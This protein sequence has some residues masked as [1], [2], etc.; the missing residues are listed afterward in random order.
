MKNVKFGLL[1]TS[2]VLATSLFLASCNKSEPAAQQP[3]AEQSQAPAASA[4]QSDIANFPLDPAKYTL[5]AEQVFS[6]NLSG[7]PSSMDPAAVSDEL[8]LNAQIPIFETLTRQENKTGEFVPAAAESYSVSEDGKTWTFKLRPN[9]VWSDGV[10]VKAED[11]VYAFQRLVDPATASPYAGYL[12]TANILNAQEVFDGKVPPS[13]LG[14]KAVDDFT[15]EVHLSEALPWLPQMLSLNVTA[16]VRKDVVEKFGDQWVQPGNIV[17]NGAFLLDSFFPTEKAVY[18]KNPNYWNAANVH[19]EQMTYTFVADENTARLKYLSGDVN[20]AKLPGNFKDQA[21]AEMPEQVLIAPELSTSFILF[22]TEKYSDPKFRRVLKLLVD[23][24]VLVDKIVKQ[25][26]VTTLL[27]PKYVT[28]GELGEEEAYGAQ[29][30]ATRQA[31]AQ[32]LLAELGI[33]KDNPVEIQFLRA[34]TPTNDR[35]AVAVVEMVETGS[36]GAIKIKDDPK[37]TKTY[38]ADRTASKYGITI[39]GW[40]ADYNQASTFYNMLRCGEPVNST[41]WCNKDYDALLAQAVLEK[42]AHK[43]AELYAQA[44]VL[45]QQETP[46]VNLWNRE[47]Y[48]L[49][50]TK[51]GG[52]NPYLNNFY[53]QDYFIID[54]AASK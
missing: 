3:A 1:A 32:Q 49:K 17:T 2:L 16:P 18:K 6:M 40:G 42:D 37:E 24:D 25:G 13:E 34:R 47:L 26:R 7:P 19:L 38:F 27:A 22:N 54:E 44:N 43:R 28:E 8:S 15:F 10:P 31:E 51:V 9:A 35:V 21:L 52:V 29:D 23:E 46:L 48:L 30:M 33:S 36:N 45:V 4:V 41:L 5:A 14:V 12:A 53:P 39:G 11:F 50:N 20:M